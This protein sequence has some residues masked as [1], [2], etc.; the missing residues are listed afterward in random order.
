MLDSALPFNTW[1]HK[2]SA[3]V[4]LTVL[5][6]CSLGLINSSSAWLVALFAAAVISLYLSLGLRACSYGLARLQPIVWIGIIML[7]YFCVIGQWLEGLVLVVKFSLL[8]A[9]ANLV[10]M[11]TQLWAMID[12]IK[13]LLAPLDRLGVPS[14]RIAF[15]LAMTIR[16]IPL[17]RLTGE[18]LILAWRARS[19]SA[20]YW[21]ILPSL[22]LQAIDCADASCDAIK[23]R[24]NRLK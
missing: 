1:A 5:V 20:Q 2:P 3:G 9:L 12:C 22:L 13:R 10:T 23:A 16:F 7:S 21:R 17:L 4:K 6:V 18:Q 19:T 8:L 24:S 11:T 15:S 14:E